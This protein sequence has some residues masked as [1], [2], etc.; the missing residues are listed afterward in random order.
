MLH[1]M[2]EIII[3]NYYDGDLESFSIRARFYT[4]I[5]LGEEIE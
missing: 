1:N 5:E 3:A 4:W 2:C